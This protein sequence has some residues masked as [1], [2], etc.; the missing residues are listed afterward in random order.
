MARYNIKD[1]QD[2]VINTIVADAAFVAA[3][4]TNYELLPERLVPRIIPTGDFLKRFDMEKLGAILDDALSPNASPD[5]RTLKGFIEVLRSVEEVD[6]DDPMTIGGLTVAV[7][8]IP[9]FAQA[10]MDAILA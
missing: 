2:N 10:D 4:Y 6:L 3:N 5:A 8:R 7:S 9:E 1:A